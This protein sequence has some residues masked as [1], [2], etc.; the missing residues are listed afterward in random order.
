MSHHNILLKQ[1]QEADGSKD[2]G[3]QGGVVEVAYVSC[4]FLSSTN[5][6]PIGKD[7]GLV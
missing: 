5:I 7:N 3:D 4:L 1:S 2:R 6:Y